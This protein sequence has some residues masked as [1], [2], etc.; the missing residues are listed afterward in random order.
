MV[1][2]RTSR[3][4]KLTFGGSCGSGPDDSASPSSPMISTN[5]ME[6]PA[7]PSQVSYTQYYC[8]EN[9][10]LLAQALHAQASHRSQWD[11]FVVVI[12]NLTRSVSLPNL[13][14]VS[15]SQ[16]FAQVALWN[17]KGSRGASIP[18]VWDYHVILVLRPAHTSAIL[19]LT[20]C[21]VYDFDSHATMP[22][23]FTG[24]FISACPYGLLC[25]YTYRRVCLSDI[26]FYMF[27]ASPV[28]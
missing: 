23:K 19:H 1:V 24:M 22:C 15:K 17:Q 16:L 18:V 12:S 28:P 26:R 5:I 6:P 9:I 4:P 27:A 20:G 2:T 21:W 11:V 14:C 25:T 8:E 10:Y 7:V 13:Y 3:D